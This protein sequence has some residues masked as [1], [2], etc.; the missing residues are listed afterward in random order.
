MLS[1]TLIIIIA[2]V[3]VSIS[4]FN[5]AQIFQKSLMNPFIIFKKNEYWRLITS[6]FIHNNYVHLGFNMFTFYFFGNLLVSHFYLA[7]AIVLIKFNIVEYVF[8]KFHLQ[9]Q[10][11]GNPAQTFYTKFLSKS[12]L[13]FC[14]KKSVIRINSHFCKLRTQLNLA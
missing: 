9:K 14:K 1:I 10:R 2:T 8:A 13:F 7:Y 4:A 5:N 12:N 11:S 6:G 3:V